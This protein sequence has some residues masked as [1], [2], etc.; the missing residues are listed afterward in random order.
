MSVSVSVRCLCVCLCVCLSVVCILSVRCLSLVCVC[1]CPLSVSCLCV[2]L[3]VVSVC[4]SPRF[5]VISFE[6]FS[7]SARR[8]IA[9]YG[10]RRPVLVEP[11][12]SDEDFL[13]EEGNV[14]LSFLCPESH[15]GHH[16]TVPQSRSAKQYQEIATIIAAAAAA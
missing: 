11:L 15:P 7:I 2:C 8:Y 13:Y 9:V 1:V 6:T 14:C 12:V 16:E 4:V 5:S 10:L 3:S